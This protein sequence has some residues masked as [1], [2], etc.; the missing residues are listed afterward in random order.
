MKKILVYSLFA[1]SFLFITG[2]KK[3][4][5]NFPFTV[6]VVVINAEGNE[7]P[8]SG[9]VVNAGAPVPDALPDFTDTTNSDGQ[10]SFTYQYEAVLQV[11]AT[12]GFN[13]PSYIGCGFIKLIQD[14]NVVL[15]I[16]LQPYD[17]SQQ[18]C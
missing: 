11:V 1:L 6:Q 9:V 4:S 17:P 12:R 13:P 10:V 5:N 15:K 7:V 8:V 2:C 16:V 3:N 18:G 14:E